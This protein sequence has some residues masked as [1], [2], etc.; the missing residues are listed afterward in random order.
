M[1]LLESV[2]MNRNQGTLRLDVGSCG[3]GCLSDSVIMTNS[4][5]LDFR[6]QGVAITPLF[7]SEFT[8]SQLCGLGPMIRDLRVLDP[9]PRP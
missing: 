6:M 3:T 5:L 8:S 1:R 4:R 2:D 7:G 9:L